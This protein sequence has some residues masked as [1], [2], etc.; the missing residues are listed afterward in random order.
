MS[1]LSPND[2][3]EFVERLES[4]DLQSERLGHWRRLYGQLRAVAGACFRGQDSDHTLQPTALVHELYLKL[5][6]NADL[7]MADESA[8]L[9][10]AARTMR[11]ILVDRARRRSAQKRGGAACLVPLREDQVAAQENQPD[12]LDLNEALVKLES[13]SPRQVQ[14]LELRYFAGLTVAEVAAVLRLSESSVKTDWIMARAWLRRA[15]GDGD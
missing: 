3:L 12:L 4:G 14:V 9:A 7:A 10:L 8:F 13:L 2:A 15:M 1:D 5:E 11:H 6:R